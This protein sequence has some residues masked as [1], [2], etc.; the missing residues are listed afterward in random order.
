MSTEESPITNDSAL[1]DDTVGINALLAKL[2]PTIDVVASTVLKT[3]GKSAWMYEPQSAR[4]FIL[5]HT[6]RYLY[7]DTYAQVPTDRAARCLG[8]AHDEGHRQGLLDSRHEQH[9]V[10]SYIHITRNPIE[11]E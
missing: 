7:C 8:D 6:G 4:L 3:A 2:P 10:I 11:A 9:M 1:V 5:S